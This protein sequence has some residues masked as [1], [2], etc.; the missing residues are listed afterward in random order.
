VVRRGMNCQRKGNARSRQERRR[1]EPRTP[2]SAPMVIRLWC[3]HQIFNPNPGGLA[4]SSGGNVGRG[5]Y[6]VK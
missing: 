4:S 2:L 3:V 1:L 6:S 5:F